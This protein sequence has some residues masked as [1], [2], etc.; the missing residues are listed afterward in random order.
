MKDEDWIQ[1]VEERV[2]DER[3]IAQ[4]GRDP[5]LEHR[6]HAKRGEDEKRCEIAGGFNPGLRAAKQNV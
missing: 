3:D 4:D 6:L 5:E 1:A 2:C